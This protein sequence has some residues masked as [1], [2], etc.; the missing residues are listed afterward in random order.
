MELTLMLPIS[1]SSIL[2][3][4]ACRH[5]VSSSADG[6]LCK[7]T[8]RAIALLICYMHAS[9]DRVSSG[10]CERPLSAWMLWMFMKERPT[11]VADLVAKGLRMEMVPLA[12]PERL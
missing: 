10:D 3:K 9:N 1:R 4:M 11:K 8:N 6:A 12:E 5:I 2:R 7:A